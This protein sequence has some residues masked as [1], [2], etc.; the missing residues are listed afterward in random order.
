MQDRERWAAHWTELDVACDPFEDRI[1][2]IERITMRPHPRLGV[3]PS[4]VVTLHSR[5]VVDLEG[6]TIN[7]E[8]TFKSTIRRGAHQLSLWEIP[9]IHVGHW[10]VS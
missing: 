6:V 5:R 7:C 2:C 8:F 4:P 10:K 1:R 9:V 3:L